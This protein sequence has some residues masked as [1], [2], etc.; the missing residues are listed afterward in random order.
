MLPVLPVA[1]ARTTST[2]Q[3]RHGRV[4]CSVDAIYRCWYI[5]LTVSVP[6]GNAISILILYD[7]RHH[8]LPLPCRRVFSLLRA[9]PVES[10][11]LATTYGHPAA[12]PNLPTRPSWAQPASLVFIRPSVHGSYLLRP[13]CI[14]SVVVHAV[15][16]PARPNK[17][18]ARQVVPPHPMSFVLCPPRCIS[19][20][21]A[22]GLCI[23]TA[24]ES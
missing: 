22:V 6:H 13:S 23:S 14:L 5:T 9:H 12:Q 19:F 1:Q 16:A 11:L 7:S 20:A 21:L 24:C 2:Y 17:R 15:T 3:W 18:G 8:F 10:A 4:A